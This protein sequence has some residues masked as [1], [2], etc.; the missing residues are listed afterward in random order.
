VRVIT[1]VSVLLVLVPELL[2]GPELV[3]ELVPVAKRLPCYVLLAFPGQHLRA[4]RQDSALVGVAVAAESAATVVQAAV[5]A[6]M[7]VLAAAAHADRGQR[8]I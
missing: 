2:P 7:V 4:E 5:P 8:R 6:A 1:A 3:P